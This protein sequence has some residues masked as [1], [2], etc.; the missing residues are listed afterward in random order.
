MARSKLFTALDAERGRN[1]KLEKQ[2]RLQQQAEK[3]KKSKI[4][5]TNGEEKEN[6][7]AQPNNKASEVEAESD[8]IDA[9]EAAAVC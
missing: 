1:Y 4:P 6:I 7:Q 9:G 5:I 8:R 2:K 3:R